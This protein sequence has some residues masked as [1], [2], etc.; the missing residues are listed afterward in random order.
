MKNI[1]YILLLS[2][3]AVSCKKLIEIPPSPPGQLSTQKVFA[4]SSDVMSAVAGIYLNFNVNTTALGFHSGAITYY[5]GLSGDELMSNQPTNTALTQL[6]VDAVTSDNGNVGSL[7]SGPTGP[8][9]AIYQI[10]ACLAGIPGCTTISQP[11]KNQLIGEIKVVRALYYFNLVNIFGGVP[12]VTA[13]D[14]QTN[15][16]LARASVDSVYSLIIRDLTDARS[17]LTPAYPSAGRARPNLYTADALLAKAYLYRGQWANAAA[18]AGEVINS[19]NYLLRA[20]LDSVFYDGSKEAIWQLPS[21]G[22]TT[23]IAEGYSFVPSSATI[24]PNYYMNSYLVNAFE[25]G[26]MRWTK[27]VKTNVNGGNNY[28]YPYKYKNLTTTTPVKEDYMILRL[29]EQ[30]LI[31]AEALAQQSKLDSALA[32]L[33]TIRARA[34]LAVS[35]AVGQTD[36][37]AAIMHERQIELFCEWGN[38]WYDLKRTG[39]I[40]TVLG[41]EKPSY[42]QPYA[43]LYPVPI[44][45]I[46]SNPFLVQNSGYN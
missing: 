29:A 2:V 1:L 41:T 10:N 24:V 23:Q 22:T 38:R 28:N 15:D 14:F 8:Y 42:W 11:L 36:V 40:N 45:E 21:I 19:G 34:G 43:A 7:W 25:P 4:D 13:T 39:T 30:Y 6:Y 16:T 35:A 27:W 46:R 3:L 33:N 31:Q 9:F 18:M 12:V 26:D 44:S 37:L 20:G 5:T 17:L 32:D